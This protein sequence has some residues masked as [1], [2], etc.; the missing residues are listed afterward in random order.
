[1]V[2]RVG[3]IGGIATGKSS[4]A[5]YFKA[6]GATII[7]TDHLA[8]QLC[9]PNTAFF[10][11]IVNYFGTEVLINGEL[12]RQALK[13]I[14]FNDKEKKAWL[15]Q[16]L[17]PAIQKQAI[18]QS[19]HAKPYAIIMIPLLKNKKS[20]LLNTVMRTTCSKKIQIERLKQRDGIDQAF[21]DRI[22]NNQASAI[23]QKML[24]DITIDTSE[25]IDKIKATIQQLHQQF[26]QNGK[27]K[28]KKFKP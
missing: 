7:D 22:L 10:Q 23:K 25:S 5:E 11:A 1:M 12:N 18:K 21:C 13:T 27:E 8:K 24:S 2:Y 9:Q 19:A 14:I 15:E 4:I 20:Y 16:L 28:N 6:L 17:H 3:L 26:S